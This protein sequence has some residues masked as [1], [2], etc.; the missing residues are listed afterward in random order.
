M[1]KGVFNDYVPNEED[2]GEILKYE[3]VYGEGSG[4]PDKI[5]DRTSIEEFEQTALMI[6]KDQLDTDILSKSAYELACMDLRAKVKRL[7]KSLNN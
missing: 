6:L 1:I 7:L 3:V 2:D 4:V 5:H